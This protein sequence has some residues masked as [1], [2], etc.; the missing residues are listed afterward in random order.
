MTR[1]EPDAK[2]AVLFCLS[3]FG[4]ALIYAVLEILK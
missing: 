3:I 1:N 4:M 2:F